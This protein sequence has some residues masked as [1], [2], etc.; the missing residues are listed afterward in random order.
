MQTDYAKN[1]STKKMMSLSKND[2]I[3]LWDG[4]KTRTIKSMVPVSVLN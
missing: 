3:Q 1:G 2:Q 4:F